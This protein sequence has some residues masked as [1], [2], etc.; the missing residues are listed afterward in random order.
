VTNVNHDRLGD[1]VRI[2]VWE[3][4]PEPTEYKAGLLSRVYAPVVVVVIRLRMQWAK[5]V[6][7]FKEK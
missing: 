7:H 5:H 6:A 3:L 1:Y 2:A 4:N